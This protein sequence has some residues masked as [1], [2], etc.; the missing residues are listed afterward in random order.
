MDFSELLTECYLLT[1]RPD[2]VEETKSAIRAATL[3][4]HHSDFYSRDIYETVITA[5]EAAYI[6]SIDYPSIISNFRAIKYL[7]KIDVATGQASAFIDVITPEEV[8]D[9]YSRTK[10]DVAYVAGR[11]IELRSSTEVQKIILGCYVNPVITEGSYSSWVADLF[12]YV[13]IYEAA[14]VLFKMT[15]FDEQAAQY[16]SLAAEQLIMLRNSAV[17]DVGS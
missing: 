7:R 5:D 10:N 2:L 8:L 1:G 17:T 16:N 9:S 3:K 4:A 6:H 14:R 12:P 11:A 15:G 13:I